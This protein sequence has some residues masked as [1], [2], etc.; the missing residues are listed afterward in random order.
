MIVEKP[1]IYA[2]AEFLANRDDQP[3]LKGK[4]VDEIVQ[5]L[6]KR[7]IEL[8]KDMD[9]SAWPRYEDVPVDI[10]RG[11]S[12]LITVATNGEE[13]CLMINVLMRNDKY[14][15]EG[16]PWGEVDVKDLT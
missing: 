7:I 1:N 8:T 3:T 9:F 4:T 11:V 6:A 15:P 13:P 16:D 5:V 2:V 12:G 10:W 14:R